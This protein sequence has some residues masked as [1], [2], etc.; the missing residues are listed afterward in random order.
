MQ[1]M[2]IIAII[3]LILLL[4]P[5][6]VAAWYCRQEGEVLYIEQDYAKDARYFGKA[7]SKMIEGNF[8]SLEDGN[9][10]LSKEEGFIDVQ[11]EEIPKEATEVVIARGC[12]F[13]T[14][15]KTKIFEK[16]IYGEKS[17]VIT[18]G[19]V[20]VRAVYAKKKLI[21]GNNTDI[22]RW[23]D[24]E[25]TVAIYDGCDLGISASAGKKLSVGRNCTFHRLFAP[26]ILI[27]QYPNDYS[28]AMEGRDARIFE[29]PGGL[30][31]KRNLEY[32]DKR[33]LDGKDEA[34]FTVLSK[35]N[36]TVL[37]GII[38]RG[39]LRSH[40]SV[41]ICDNAVVC[42]NIFAEE[43]VHIGRDAVVLG[44]IFSQGNVYFEEGAMVGQR[45]KIISV[46]AR[47]KIYFGGR[48]FVFGFVSCEDGGIVKAERD[49]DKKYEELF[50]DLVEEKK[51]LTFDN[52]EAYEK[53]M[54]VG[55]R[56]VDNLQRV[57]I[58]QMATE[59]PRSM[60]YACSSLSY[61]QMPQTIESIGEYAFAD[62]KEL[63]KIT[64]LAY[65]RIKE[66][67]TSAFENCIRLQQ[68]DFPKELEYL[69]DAAFAGCT[70]LKRVTFTEDCR[71]K[72]ISDHCFKGCSQLE[73]IELPDTVETV[74]I[75]AFA[76][77][78]S[79]RYISIPLMC[80]E[81][82]G[83]VELMKNSQINLYIRGLEVNEEIKDE[84]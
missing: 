63:D 14:P 8:S 73:R 4:A 37:E 3:F 22:V 65:M 84:A 58:P 2:I 32:I 51:K 82:P 28:D 80:A 18:E 19:G 79:L 53:V 56:K 42:G 62:C 47:R 50:L 38:L 71:L 61:V 54:S 64:S 72:T 27:G 43:D 25:E 52:L 7:F 67:K 39:D 36:V 70:G 35:H 13:Q 5:F 77:C 11:T 10:F 66:I 23:V 33:L 83:I 20:R 81:E 15:V 45:G 29:I 49:S 75:S 16:E 68:V 6:M 76:D 17:V 41:R 40:K 69:G 26:E 74:G 9:I 46:I 21:L 59:V 30:E 12:D 48:A 34:E 78:D 60:F 24:A 57:V 31:I 1:Y 44:N 55:F